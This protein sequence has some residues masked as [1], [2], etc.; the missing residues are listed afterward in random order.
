MLDRGF[1]RLVASLRRHWT[2]PVRRLLELVVAE[3]GLGE[4]VAHDDTA[5]IAVRSVGASA[6]H[7]VDVVPAEREQLTLARHRLQEWLDG[8]VVHDQERAADILLAAN[9]VIANALEHGSEFDATKVV[10]I[11]AG[12]SDGTLTMCVRD[13]GRWKAGVEAERPDRGR[14]FVLVEQLTDA[15]HIEQESAGTRVTLTWS[16]TRS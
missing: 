8:V 9:E 3:C 4:R 14:G 1:E 16:L 13:T 6:A 11:E 12:V 15:V 10:T 5:L 7:L 2:L